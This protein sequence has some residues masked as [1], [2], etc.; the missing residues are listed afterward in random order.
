MDNETT[1]KEIDNNEQ[2]FIAHIQLKL[3]KH[4]GKEA[5]LFL[6]EIDQLAAGEHRMT[7]CGP[8]Y[9]AIHAKYPLKTAVKEALFT[10]PIKTETIR[11]SYYAKI[12]A[13]FRETGCFED[14]EEVPKIELS[15][16]YNNC[17]IECE[18]IYLKIVLAILDKIVSTKKGNS[19]LDR[20]VYK[21]L[22][23]YKS[24]DPSLLDLTKNWKLYKKEMS[25]LENEI[26]KGTNYSLY[27][28]L[29]DSKLGL[30]LPNNQFSKINN[31]DYL[32]LI[33]EKYPKSFKY[34]ES[35]L[36]RLRTA[37]TERSDSLSLAK[38]CIFFKK[39]NKQL[40]SDCWNKILSYLS[41]EDLKNVAKAGD[42]EPHSN[43]ENI[44]KLK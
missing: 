33:R 30:L 19:S 40:N 12:L 26:I 43:S 13:I 20:S 3:K 29:S 22:E 31:S 28:I 37:R 4:Y 7:K 36:C 23:K 14:N 2:R 9:Y 39:T 10:N 27:D 34:I 35:K 42:S 17:G 24:D 15:I 6:A 5:D 44:P 38:D 25:Q 8:T 18:D 32:T 16:I 11:G 21:F 1:E 41:N